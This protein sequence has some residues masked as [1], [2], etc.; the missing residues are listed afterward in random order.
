[1]HSAIFQINTYPDAAIV[2]SD[3]YDDHWFTREI[4]DYVS[5]VDDAIVD[6]YISALGRH[7]GLRVDA[8]SRTITV[9]SREDYFR[10]AY[11]TFS[12]AASVISAASLSD[13]ANGSAS[14]H[15]LIQDAQFNYD[16]KF[17]YY[18]ND[19]GEYSGLVTLDEW[20]RYVAITGA[21]YHIINALD[22]H[23]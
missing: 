21:P 18:V 12:S 6:E 13:F 15:K 22:Y 14:V 9:E 19:G 7:D 2:R 23:F 11:E 17:G 20:V 5:D 16:D 4:A 8:E 1:M 3:A 10:S